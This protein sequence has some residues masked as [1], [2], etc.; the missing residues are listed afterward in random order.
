MKRAD[1]LDADE[2]EL[3]LMTDRVPAA[4]R[5]RILERPDAFKKLVSMTDQQLDDFVGG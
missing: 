3:L 4:I 5:K 1:A 2:D